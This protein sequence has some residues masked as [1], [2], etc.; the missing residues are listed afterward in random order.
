[1][2]SGTITDRSGRTLSGQ[3]PAAF[4]QSIRH[5]QPLTV[6][7]NCALGA[8]E[9]RPHV[10]E[11]SARRRH[12]RLRVPERRAAQRARWLRRAAGHDGRLHRTSS[13]R[14]AS[15]TSSAAAAA[16][17]R[18]TSRRSP[19]PSTGSR[20]AS[21]RRRTPRL[22]LSGLEPF[23]LTDDIPFVNVGERTNITGSAK[24]RR[25]IKDNDYA[26]ALD[27]ARDQVENGAQIIDVNMDDGLIDGVEAMTTF[28]NLIAGEP[29]IARV[30]VM[31]DSS[32]FSVIE[33]GLQCVQGKPIVNSISMKEGVEQF[34]EQARICLDYGAAVI[35]MAFDEV[36]QADTVERK[37]DIARRAYHLLVDEVGFPPDDI[38]IDP[39]IF[40]IATGMEE[41]DRYGLDFIEAT[42]LITDELPY[43]NISGGVSNLSFSFR[44]N[45]PV[46][47][48]MHSVFLLRTIEAGM[49]LGI[50]N[51]GQLAVYDQIDPELRELCEDVVL[52]RRPD[53][54]ER[55]LDAA[56]RFAGTGEAA[57][58]P[59]AA[60]WRSW[61]VDRRL[62]HAL[63]NGITAF[64]EDDVEEAR[65]R[66]PAAPST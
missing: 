15:S 33:A 20:R 8:E 11:L 24:F 62:E 42:K 54:T 44:G 41:H 34:L 28:L 49:R 61:D 36:G 27:V 31:I 53:A 65:V 63:V 57:A 55:L 25:L 50:V 37:V 51:A 9:M 47:E 19:R 66:P 29:E 16:P 45:E 52:A 3:T 17:R 23:A 5:A 38:I 56:A 58:D 35:V 1:M 21:C 6:G 26:E 22:E 13:P 43:V 39:N 7:L 14:P 10:E 60:G 46:R 64:I 32:K 40:A 18:R 12:V 59:V 48:A 30:P 2:I 4:W